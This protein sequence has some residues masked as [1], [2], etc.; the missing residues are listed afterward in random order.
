MWNTKCVCLNM[1]K[2]LKELPQQANILHNKFNFTNYF[3]DYRHI[4]VK[5]FGKVVKMPCAGGGGLSIN[6]K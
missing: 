5:T 2:T 6:K 3:L 4:T 1:K